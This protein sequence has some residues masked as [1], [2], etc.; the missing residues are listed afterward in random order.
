[1]KYLGIIALFIFS[2]IIVNAQEIKLGENEVDF[3]DV[4]KSTKQLVK[5]VTIYNTGDAPLIITNVKP[6][7][8]CTVPSWPKTPIAPGKSATM[9]IKYSSTTKVG[10]FSKA[11]TV[12]SNSVSQPRLMVRVKGNITE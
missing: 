2:A 1:M 7:C 5:D 8:G 10:R 12:L 11:I 6:T 9:T 4:Q 3:G